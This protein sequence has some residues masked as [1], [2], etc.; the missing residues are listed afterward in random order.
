[1]LVRLRRSDARGVSPVHHNRQCRNPLLRPLD[2]LRSPLLAP[3]VRFWDDSLS[4][5]RP[6]PRPE[7]IT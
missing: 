1:M 7:F 5:P 2:S 3:L 6:L 4:R